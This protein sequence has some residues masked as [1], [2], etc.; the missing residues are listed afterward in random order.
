MTAGEKKGRA[1][2]A[3][4]VTLAGSIIAFF[5]GS[6]FATAQEIVQYFVAY[7]SLFLPVILLTLL[8]FGY[9]DY[10]FLT[11]GASGRLTHSSQIFRHY[12]GRY[13]G[14][15]FDGF[16]IL[17][18]F[19]SFVVMLGGTNAMLHQQYGA[20]LGLGA[21]ILAILIVVVVAAGLNGMLSALGKLGPIIIALVIFI[22]VCTLI[23]DGGLAAHGVAQ[24]DSGEVQLMNVGGNPIL[25]ALS[26]SGFVLLWFATFM[27]EMGER[28]GKRDSANA[29]GMAVGVICLGLS[30]V[31]LAI[32]THVE[33]LA[34]V[35]IPSLILAGRISPAFAYCFSVVIMA[36]DFTTGAPLLWTVAARFTKEGTKAYKL[37]TVGLGV[38]GVLIALFLPYRRLV[39]VVYG[40]S[41]YIGAAFLVCIL[42]HDIRSRLNKRSAAGKIVDEHN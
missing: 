38:A 32:F 17:L 15:F 25:S 11:A 23:N 35:D 29:V 26:Y 20:P 3:V 18:C 41:G 28:Q 36:G 2:L 34:A 40:Y 5:L 13:L 42:F 7:G 37:L 14:A 22:A 1:G 21:I 8:I 6:G 4:V 39:N 27:A 19:L 10:S 9:T 33:E 12:A 30:L 24:V 16:T 31:A